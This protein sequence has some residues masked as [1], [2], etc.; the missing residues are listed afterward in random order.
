ME[1][2]IIIIFLKSQPNKRS[3]SVIGS[4]IVI[5]VVV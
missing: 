5:I 2:D 1:N 4:I 3:G